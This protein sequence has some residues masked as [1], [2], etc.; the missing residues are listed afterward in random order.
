[1]RIALKFDMSLF[2]DRN[3]KVDTFIFLQ[4]LYTYHYL[5]GKLK[6]IV[7]INEATALEVIVN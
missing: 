2:G 5:I 6:V 4:L 3:S 1:M 7:E